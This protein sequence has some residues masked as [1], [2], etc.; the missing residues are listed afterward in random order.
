MIERLEPDDAVVVV[1]VQNDLCPGGALPVP[2]GDEVVP[3]L[4][5][6]ID[7]AGQVEATVVVSRDWHPADHCSFRPR[8]GPWPVHCVRNT[9]GADYH[10]D[11][12]VPENALVVDKATEPDREN[13]S[14]FAGTGVGDELRRK[15]VTRIWVGGLAL[16]YCVRATVLDGLAE[17]FEVH[18]L[19]PA[20]RAVDVEAGDGERAT[21][22][23]R[24]H[25]AVIER[26]AT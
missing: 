2:G 20:T 4:N 15:G 19:L 3:V 5:R 18:V 7:K 14:D 13:F 25:G 23:M 24:R 26:D 10:P 17:G 6:W 21:E 8:G 11:L 9:P 12:H 16:D 1:D 22:E